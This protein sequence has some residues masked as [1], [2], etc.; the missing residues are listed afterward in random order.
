M[1]NTNPDF[2]MKS[3]I[4][5]F[6]LLISISVQS[7]SIELEWVCKDDSNISEYSLSYGMESGVIKT[8]KIGKI[9]NVRIDTLTE[10]KLY[11][12]QITPIIRPGVYGKPSNVIYYKVPSTIFDDRHSTPELRI[13]KPKSL[14][15]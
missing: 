3:F 2:K 14:A 12:F 10:G 15:P 1:E 7:A 8:T 5:I 9:N 11:W 4:F 6:A 13:R